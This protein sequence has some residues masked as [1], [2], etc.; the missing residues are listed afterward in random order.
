MPDKHDRDRQSRQQI[1]ISV[2]LACLGGQESIAATVAALRRQTVVAQMQLLIVAAEDSGVTASH[3]DLRVFGSVAV[4][5]VDR[6]TSVARANAAGVRAATAPVVGFSEDHAF[7]DPNWAESLIEAHVQDWTAVG[8]AVRNANPATA[9]SW[10]DFF[11]G[12]GPWAD[13]TPAGVADFLPGHNSSYKRAA[14]LEYDGKLEDM[15]EAETVLHWD[16]RKKG[17]KLYLE[18]AAKI[19]H[20]NFSLLSSWVR[21]QFY[22]GWV[23]AG[24]RLLTMSALHRLV[25]FGGAPLIP[26]VRFARIC[27]HIRRAKNP[28]CPLARVLP[29]LF[30]G[31][32][33]DGIGQM[34]GYAFGT[35]NAKDKLAHLEFHRV[36]HVTAADR[37]MLRNRAF[38]GD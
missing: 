16:L 27:K 24:S 17:H 9:V 12:Y 28:E 20:T 5:A 4:V 34:L 25:Y 18:P 38:G 26:L 2:V 15:L 23:F 19:S 30:F 21:A 10:S 36:E 22:C 32:A 37:E 13:P 8:P 7:P 35:M 3:P 6:V 14:L 33:L 31:L 11:I 29:V 1:R